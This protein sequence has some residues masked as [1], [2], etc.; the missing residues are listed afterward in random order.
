MLPYDP[1]FVIALV[2]TLN[3]VIYLSFFSVI[4]LFYEHFVKKKGML[5]FQH[6]PQF[7]FKCCLHSTLDKNDTAI[8]LFKALQVLSVHIT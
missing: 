3:F 7:T 4:V 1:P 2:L 5:K 6:S 8:G